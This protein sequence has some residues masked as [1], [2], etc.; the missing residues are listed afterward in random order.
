MKQLTVNEAAAFLL[1]RDRFVIL[2]HR[3]PDG[4]TVGCAAALCRALRT[5]GVIED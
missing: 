2:T 5:T 3:R 4:D 1:A